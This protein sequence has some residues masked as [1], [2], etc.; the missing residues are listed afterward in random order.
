MLGTCFGWKWA[1]AATEHGR[2]PR[3]MCLGQEQAGTKQQELVW[4]VELGGTSCL[5]SAPWLQPS[6][7]LREMD[8]LPATARARTS[9]E[10][11][12]SCFP[13][14]PSRTQGTS[15]GQWGWGGSWGEAGG[16]TAL[17]LLQL[18]P[19][20]ETISDRPWLHPVCLG[21]GFGCA[22]PGP[23]L[24][25]PSQPCCGLQGCSCSQ[26]WLSPKCQRVC[27]YPKT[28]ALGRVGSCSHPGTMGRD[29]PHPQ[30]VGTGMHVTGS[31]VPLRQ[32]CQGPNLGFWWGSGARG[33]LDQSNRGC[34]GGP[35]GS[36]IPG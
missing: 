5:S 17:G 8:L 24:V 4:E 32:S 30:H 1:Q 15:R 36:G 25:A 29:V 26:I 16:Q 23:H 19:E 9:N 14:S 22:E 33:R 3:F 13:G 11:N 6:P 35:P 20:Q 2:L 27:R 12:N 10:Q 7:V 28:S 31:L 18:L 34:L 21:W